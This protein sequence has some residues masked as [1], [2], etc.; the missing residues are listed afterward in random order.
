MEALIEYLLG[1]S[2]TVP[3]GAAG[4]T[5]AAQNLLVD[6][7]ADDYFTMTV[8][9][10]LSADDVEYQVEISDDLAVWE[11]G[12]GHV[13]HVSSTNNGD[14]TLTVVYR[15]ADPIGAGIQEYFRLRVISRS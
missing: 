14:G 13:E 5:V 15:S 1:T 12:S 9:L 8:V 2:D 4:P 6:T 10:D 11:S 7:V 3:S